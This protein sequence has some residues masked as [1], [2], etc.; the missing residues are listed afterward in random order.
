[1]RNRRTAKAPPTAAELEVQRKV[2]EW[3]AE[4]DTDH[5]DRLEAAEIREILK[6]ENARD[7]KV[8]AL[9]IERWVSLVGFRFSVFGFR[10]FDSPA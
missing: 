5:T 9:L 4:F 10:H 7:V 1:M 6:R 8:G 2:E 3:F